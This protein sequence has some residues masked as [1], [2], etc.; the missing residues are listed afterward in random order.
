[1]AEKLHNDFR[2][3][4]ERDL[5]AD[6]TRLRLYLEDD[7]TVGVLVGHVM[8]RIVD[9]YASFRETVWTVY[10]DALRGVLF[11]TSTVKEMLQRICEDDDVGSSST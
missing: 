6:V 1:M 3:A 9:D 4:C 5:R 2:L 10:T 8:D 7:R 11:S